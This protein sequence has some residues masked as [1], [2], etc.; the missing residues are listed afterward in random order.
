MLLVRLRAVAKNPARSGS[1]AGQNLSGFLQ[2]MLGGPLHRC[3][4]QT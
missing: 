1:H 4:F 2:G 3:H